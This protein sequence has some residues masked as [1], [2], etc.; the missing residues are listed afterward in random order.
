M[1][2]GKVSGCED[3]E[4]NISVSSVTNRSDLRSKNKDDVTNGFGGS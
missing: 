2:E 4:D 3:D 1:P